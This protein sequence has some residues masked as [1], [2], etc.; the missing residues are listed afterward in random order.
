MKPAPV[1]YQQ[2]HWHL[3][4][5]RDHGELVECTSGPTCTLRFKVACPA[6]LVNLCTG[7]ANSR[8]TPRGYGAQL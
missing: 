6:C 5:F 2:T 7:R 8:V 1:R 3:C 4:A